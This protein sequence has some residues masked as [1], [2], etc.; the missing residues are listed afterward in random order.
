[1]VYAG[2]DLNDGAPIPDGFLLVGSGGAVARVTGKGVAWN[3]KRHAGDALAGVVAPGAAQIATGGFD[4]DIAIS[5]G[6]GA[7]LRR[8]KADKGWVTALAWRG[9]TLIS[10]GVSGWLRRWDPATGTLHDETR[11]HTRSILALA[12]TPSHTLTASEDASAKIFAAD[13]TTL[14]VLKVND[15]PVEAAALDGRHAYTGTRDGLV[16][17]WDLETGAE[18]RTF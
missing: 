3:F 18:L 14:H 8:W 5:D 2:T 1:M 6:A 15:M 12:M 17:V 11:V 9:D 10:G 13:Y 7:E 4:G 16:R